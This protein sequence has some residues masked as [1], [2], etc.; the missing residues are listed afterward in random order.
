MI[1][2]KAAATRKRNQRRARAEQRK[3]VEAARKDGQHGGQKRKRN[4]ARRNPRPRPPKESGPRNPPARPRLHRKRLHPVQQNTR[5]FMTST[6]ITVLT[7]RIT[8]NMRQG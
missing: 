4:Y 2:A 1:A 5:S 3:R 8:A 6:R 7:L